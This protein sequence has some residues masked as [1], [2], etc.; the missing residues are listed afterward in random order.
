MGDTTA[1]AARSRR[2][3]SGGRVVRLREVFP[4][5]AR[6]ST[7]TAP[8]RCSTRCSCSSSRSGCSS[9]PRRRPTAFVNAPERLAAA[10]R[11]S[12]PSHT[13]T[14]ALSA[15]RPC[16]TVVR[17]DG[18]LLLHVAAAR[19]GVPRRPLLAAL[20]VNAVLLRGVARVHDRDGAPPPR[21]SRSTCGP[22]ASARY[23][24]AYA[25]SSAEPRPHE[26]HPVHDRRARAARRAG[27]LGAIASSHG[28]GR[29]ERPRR[30]VADRAAPLP[31]RPARIA[32]CRDHRVTGRPSSG[33]RGSSPVG[34][35]DREP[36]VW[37]AIAAMVLA[38]CTAAFR[39]AHAGGAGRR[40]GARR[41]V[42]DALRAALAARR[43]PARRR[44][45][46]R[47]GR[48]CG[49]RS[50]S[51]VARSPTSRRAAGSPWCYSGCTGLTLLMGGTCRRPCSRRD[52]AGDDAR[53]GDGA[54]RA[55]RA[56]RVRARGAVRGD[57]RW[58]DREAQVHEI[59]DAAP[60]P[61][62]VALFGR[63]FLALV[64]TIVLLLSRSSRRHPHPALQGYRHFELAP[65]P[66]S[67]SACSSPTTCSSRR[68]R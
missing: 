22:F 36:R 32:R 18:P 65:P 54:R 10:R 33:T 39:F 13:V 44:H 48:R 27:Y 16:A 60:V 40:A 4:L 47:S 30:G 6:A 49:R 31:R 8:R 45:V 51:T 9:P 57:W 35:A 63:R 11:S 62:G 5:R 64:A 34:G 41:A 58:A 43:R 23:A 56:D 17:R 68:S 53:R 15:T 52:L 14:A 7:S 28:P 26:R 55:R 19:G 50:G 12:A 37:L 2:R 46:R 61:E 42:A 3:R 25:S 67:S 24:Q 21:R 20:V 29:D 59:A 38:A 1:G 66:P